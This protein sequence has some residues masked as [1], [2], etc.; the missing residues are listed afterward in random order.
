MVGLP[1][2]SRAISAD[3][4]GLDSTARGAPADGTEV[5]SLNACTPELYGAPPPDDE[6][7]K[8]SPPRRPNAV[9]RAL[10]GR[11]AG[12]GCG[13]RAS[14][15]ARL[16]PVGTTRTPLRAGMCHRRRPLTP[17][18]AGRGRMPGPPLAD[19]R[20]TPMRVDADAHVDETEATWDYLEDGDRF[21]PISI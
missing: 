13:Q 5:G 8:I 15:N 17:A 18:G 10:S 2:R 6:A 9:R 12:G 11:G 16:G 21:K 7:K 19:R 1:L 14:D 3:G 4:W 20:R